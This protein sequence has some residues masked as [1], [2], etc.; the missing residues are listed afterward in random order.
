MKGFKSTLLG[1]GI[2]ILSGCATQTS[3]VYPPASLPES[4]AINLDRPAVTWTKDKATAS[5][6]KSA[7]KLV[8][9]QLKDPDSAI[10]GDVWVMKGTNGN[11]SICGYVNAK[12]SYGGYT[13]KKMFNVLS[14]SSENVIIEGSGPLG[15]LLPKLCTP[16]T[17]N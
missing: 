16:R 14:I 8:V 10:F 13:G 9:D 4:P 7:K 12:N 5:E 15:D 6:E 11:R 2:L 17:V 1:I 3:M